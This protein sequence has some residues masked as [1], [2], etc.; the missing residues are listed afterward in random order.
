VIAAVSIGFPG[1]LLLGAGITS[2]SIYDV[3][4]CLALVSL[5]WAAVLPLL[6]TEWDSLGKAL[7]GVGVR[8]VVAGIV[9][10]S[11]VAFAGQRASGSPRVF[12]VDETLYQ[13]Q[14]AYLLDSLRGMPIDAETGPFFRI[15]QTFE[16]AGF[17]TGQYPPG[18]PAALAV[19]RAAGLGDLAPSLI[20]FLS[21]VCVAALARSL[22][23]S[24]ET[25]LLA[26]ALTGTCFIHYI[27]VDSY[28]AHGF[29]GVLAM[30]AAIC[31]LRAARRD[32]RASAVWWGLG[33]LLVG[34]IVTVRPLTGAVAVLMLGWWML[35][36]RSFR[37]PAVLGALLGGIVPVLA[38]IAYNHATTGEVFRFGYDLS[39]EGL[40]ALGFGRRG[41]IWYDAAGMPVRRVI[42]F[43]P[44]DGITHF[45]V[46]LGKGLLAFWPGGL[47]FV[48]AAVYI[49][50]RE[51]LAFAKLLPFLVLPGAYALYF[52]SAI[53][54][55][56][57]CLPFAML[58]TAYL[59]TRLQKTDQRMSR[60]VIWSTVMLG[61]ASGVGQFVNRKP[62]QDS[63]SAY[64]DA[65]EA[66]RAALGPLVV[67]VSQEREPGTGAVEH[68]LE[69][70]YSYN[71]DRTGDIVVGRD[72]ESIRS[73]VTARFPGHAVIRLVTGREDSTGKW[74]PP[75]VQVLSPRYSSAPLRPGG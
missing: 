60:L 74:A 73:A 70:L 44:A 37:P 69:A 59:A 35:T 23:F 48:L 13:L 52:F 33:A 65:V 42:D 10:L 11:V 1:V 21:L 61:V 22:R 25:A 75:R 38:L 8:A 51:K 34:G 2:D 15:R 9:V 63:R 24:W 66:E 71:A 36:T 3:A 57:E 54:Y 28:F 31:L 19:L 72:V 41:E 20:Y 5:A 12:A 67:F 40:Q 62:L 32:G 53:R 6:G 43:G 55:F 58:G 49:E 45:L 29:A 27:S 46:S 4:T 14:A 18:W 30:T 16:H 17:L 68:G 7:A 50:R 56:V 47:L 64:F 39:Q 26:V